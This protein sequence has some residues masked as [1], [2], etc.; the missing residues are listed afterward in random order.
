MASSGA[1]LDFPVS[2]FRRAWNAATVSF[3]TLSVGT[4][5][6]PAG[7]RL[8]CRRAGACAMRMMAC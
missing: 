8:T 6:L 4:I 3:L 1:V 2:S 7:E 5:R